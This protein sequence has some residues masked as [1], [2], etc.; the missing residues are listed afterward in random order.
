MNPSAD[1]INM[2]LTQQATDFLE[3]LRAQDSPPVEALPLAQGRRMFASL[4][5]WFGDKPNLQSVSDYLFPG[6]TKGRIYRPESLDGSSQ[7]A[8]PAIMYFHGG[9]WVLGNLDTHDSLCRRIAEQSNCTVIAIDYSLS[10]EMRYPVALNECYDATLHVINHSSEFN[11]I[12]ERVAVAGDSAGGNLAA[13]VAMKS[14]DLS[15]PAIDLQVL[16]YPALLVDFNQPSYERYADGFGLTRVRMKWFWNQYLGKNKVDQ[17][18]APGMAEDLR[19]LPSSLIV[20]AECDVLRSE[21]ETFSAALM[22]AGVPIVYKHYQGNLHGFI[23]F[24]GIFDDGLTA[25]TD[26][27]KYCQQHLYR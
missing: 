9:G 26:V 14:R 12:P 5:R 7:Q 22:N 3:E 19:G 15:G 24:A 23:H 8:Q 20:A 18:A 10:P 1:S 2:A 4:T 11:I 27:A 21:A 16:I 13:A 25:T 6:N 17:Y